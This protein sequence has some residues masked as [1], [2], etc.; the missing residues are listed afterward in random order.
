M[1]VPFGF[2][3]F[4][5]S[6]RLRVSGF[7]FLRTSGFVSEEMQ[8]ADLSPTS[9]A[10]QMDSFSPAAPSKDEKLSSSST[11]IDSESQVSSDAFPTSSPAAVPLSASASV[12]SSAASASSGV[13]GKK[14]APP[15]KTPIVLGLQED[16][17]LLRGNWH[18][19]P[20]VVP[21]VLVSGKKFCFLWKTAPYL[22]KFLLPEKNRKKE[23]HQSL[24]TTTVIEDLAVARE[25]ERQRCFGQFENQANFLVV[26]EKTDSLGLDAEVCAPQ[27]KRKRGERK[28]EQETKKSRK[29]YLPSYTQVCLKRPSGATWAP[30]ILLNEKRESVA[31]EATL[32]NFEILA[33]LVASQLGTFTSKAPPRKQRDGIFHRVRKG[34]ARVSV[35][36]MYLPG[37]TPKTRRPFARAR[38]VR[39]IKQELENAACLPGLPKVSEDFDEVCDPSL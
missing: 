4:H 10:S 21:V 7:F 37:K 38:T 30:N 34:G 25:C 29:T 16:E 24:A 26:K 13:D 14:H 31:L 36:A 32:E 5:C 35:Q 8:S 15:G 23:G 18:K 12:S 22:Q 20:F 11:E 33:E 1:R 9:P 2:C 39:K 27:A 17:I 28:K 3:R 6:S 19:D